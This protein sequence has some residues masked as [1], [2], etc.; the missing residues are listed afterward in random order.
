MTSMDLLCGRYKFTVQIQELHISCNNI[1]DDT[2]VFISDYLNT[3][4][5]LNLSHDHITVREMSKLYKS[6]KHCISLQYVDLSGN[7][8]AIPMGCVLWYH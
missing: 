4:K 1:V 5:I 7:Y 3:V 8:L 2:A 6:I